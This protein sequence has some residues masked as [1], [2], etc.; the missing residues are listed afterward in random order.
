MLTMYPNT[1]VEV[2]GTERKG[3][4][5]LLTYSLPSCRLDQIQGTP[6]AGFHTQWV[7]KPHMSGLSAKPIP[8]WMST[9]PLMYVLWFNWSHLIQYSDMLQHYRNYYF[10][11][12]EKINHYS[13]IHYRVDVN[14]VAYRP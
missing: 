7:N 8:W 2:P 5:G 10:A 6:G 4:Y 1:F 12:T 14:C 11:V 13:S 3:W 9:I